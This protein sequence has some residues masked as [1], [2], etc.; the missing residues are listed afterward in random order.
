MYDLYPLPNNC[1]VAGQSVSTLIDQQINGDDY[2][3]EINDIDCFFPSNFYEEHELTLPV[4]FTE[5]WV[6]KEKENKSFCMDRKFA[7]SFKR[8]F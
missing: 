2:F 1:I 8:V 7:S 3:S 5:Q 6:S 4:E